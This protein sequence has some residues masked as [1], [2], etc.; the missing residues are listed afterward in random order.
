MRKAGPA[1]CQL[2]LEPPAEVG[3]LLA[4]ASRRMRV[5]A[6]F[7]GLVEHDRDRVVPAPG[8][9]Q[10]GAPLGEGQDEILALANGRR[11]PRDMAF[12]LGRG[13]YATTLQLIHMYSSGLLVTASHRAVTAAERA[14][15]SGPAAA[16]PDTA[17]ALPRRRKG[18]AQHRRDGESGAGA[19]L[20]PCGGC[21]G[22]VRP[23]IRVSGQ[24]VTNQ[25][26]SIKR[27]LRWRRMNCSPKCTRCVTA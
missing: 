22:R 27:G 18:R 15:P 5:L 12:A 23:G 7:P 19:D 10:P 2:A 14:Q 26:G 11:T 16:G 1:D 4:E 9:V 21:S 24:G 8:A 13:V 20:R 17:A 6:A 3:W 25:Y